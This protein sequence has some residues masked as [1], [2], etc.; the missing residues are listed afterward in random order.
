MGVGEC[1][2]LRNPIADLEAFTSEDHS[3]FS[4]G[5]LG[6]SN[7]YCGEKMGIEVGLRGEEY[8]V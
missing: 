4:V 1:N 6:R 8:C 5:Q 2:C 3:A 7:G